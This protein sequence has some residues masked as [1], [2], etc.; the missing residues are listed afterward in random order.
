M[1]LHSALLCFINFARGNRLLTSPVT[2]YTINISSY[3]TELTLTVHPFFPK[4]KN[5]KKN[6]LMKWYCEMAQRT[7][8]HSEISDFVIYQFGLSADQCCMFCLFT[9]PFNSKCG[10]LLKKKKVPIYLIY[11]WPKVRERRLL[12]ARSDFRVV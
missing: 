1:R 8:T 7:L 5:N 10:S 3:H 12:Q 11:L 6:G 4:K 2:W 9:H